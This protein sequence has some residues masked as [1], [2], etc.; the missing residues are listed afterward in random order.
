MPWILLPNAPEDMLLGF[1]Y[2]MGW[3]IGVMDPTTLLVVDRCRD[4]NTQWTGGL[5]LKILLP[6]I[7]RLM[8][9]TCDVLEMRCMFI[10][11]AVRL[12]VTWDVP[13]L[14]TFYHGSF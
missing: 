5:V 12:I 8:N 13:P 6:Y 9:M 4:P 1:Y 3:Q 14:G 2:P 11:S 10:N 7:G